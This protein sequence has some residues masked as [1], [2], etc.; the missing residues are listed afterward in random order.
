MFVVTNNK[1]GGLE[2]LVVRIYASC[3]AF[4]SNF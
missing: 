4:M 1:I 2:K 3:G